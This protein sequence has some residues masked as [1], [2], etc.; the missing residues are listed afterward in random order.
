[1]VS[2]VF[3]YGE[4]LNSFRNLEENEENIDMIKKLLESGFDR[5]RICKKIGIKNPR[6]ILWIA[7][8]NNFYDVY[9]KTL[10]KKYRNPKIKNPN[11]RKEFAVWLYNRNDI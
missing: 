5:H 7:R 11:A 3:Y 8:K 6:W 1:M 2:L 10:K 9:E 4:N